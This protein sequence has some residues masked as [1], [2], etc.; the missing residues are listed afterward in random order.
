MTTLE[1]PKTQLADAS[2]AESLKFVRVGLIPSVARGGGANR[3][4]ALDGISPVATKR[5]LS[6]SEAS[7]R[8]I[9]V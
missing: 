6:A 8:R 3:R 4:R 9:C 2:L 1:R 5:R 7:A